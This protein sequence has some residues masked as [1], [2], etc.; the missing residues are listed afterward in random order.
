M[1]SNASLDVKQL[2]VIRKKLSYLPVA[3]VRTENAVTSAASPK[4]LK[5]GGDLGGVG[6]RSPVTPVAQRPGQTGEL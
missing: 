5:L 3:G 1:G 4:A 2:C 6:M